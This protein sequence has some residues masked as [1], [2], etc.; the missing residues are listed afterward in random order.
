[1]RLDLA[2]SRAFGLSRRAARDAVRSG[3]VDLDGDVADEPGR[4]IGEEARISFTPDRPALHR[5]RTRL[6][7][8][9]ED[10]DFLI[11][12]KPA[13]LLTVP[14][15]EREKDT[16]HA[17]VLE[18]LHHRYRRRPVA[19]IV[20]RLDRDT[21]G[22]VVFART[23][24]ALHFLQDLFK[25]H[26]IERE[27][28][29]IV[30]GRLPESGT[31]SADLVRDRGDLRRGVA[32][33]GQPGRRAVTRY[34]ALE[35]LDGATL[36][37]VELETGRTHQIRVHFAEAGHPVLGDRVYGS[38]Q[39]TVD[40]RHFPR[41]MLH[42]RKLGF[43]HPRTGEIVR[44]ESPLPPDFRTALEELRRKKKRPGNPGRREN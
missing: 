9:A 31:F 16:L 24:E 12:E 43:P 23:R 29:A 2:V 37:A 20:H 14:T 10:P 44:A 21:S 3:R 28:A 4:E 8:L 6:S 22:A 27:Y 5:V 40:S 15:A 25:R 19:F 39:S 33:P 18:Y 42:A 34:R 35:H 13:G 41:Q 26:D 30:R 7:V 38:R 17:R 1:M 36:V 11:V 32:R